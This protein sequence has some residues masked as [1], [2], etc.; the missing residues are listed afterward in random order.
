MHR[1]LNKCLE[2][3]NLKTLFASSGLLE[4]AASEATTLMTGLQDT[5]Q[6]DVRDGYC[7]R[8]NIKVA[9]RQGD[10]VTGINFLKLISVSCFMPLSTDRFSK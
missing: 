1:N 9:R 3:V 5:L 7:W 2:A 4:V 8:M 10:Y 6:H